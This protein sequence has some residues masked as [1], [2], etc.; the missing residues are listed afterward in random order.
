MTAQPLATPAST[1]SPERS[2]APPPGI[3][4]WVARRLPPR[5]TE[6]LQS[7]LYRNG[8]ALV[9]ATGATSVLGFLYWILAARRYSARQSK[10]TV[11][12]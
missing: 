8:Y 4:K 6:H 7:P 11:T 1:P 2:T 5:V 10:S 9:V 12:R 3:P